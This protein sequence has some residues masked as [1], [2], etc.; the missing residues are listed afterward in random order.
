[1][2]DV[3]ISLDI[4]T[5][6]LDRLVENLTNIDAILDQY[7]ALMERRAKALAP[8]ETGALRASITAS[9]SDHGIT[10]SAGAGLPDPR[11][12]MQEY[13]FHHI[14]GAFIQHPYLRPAFEEYRQRLIDELTAA[15]SP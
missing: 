3:G 10:L 8:T 1:M 9:V 15:M 2:A 7:A 5:D 12:A 6:D 4:N 13:G 11:A 14:G